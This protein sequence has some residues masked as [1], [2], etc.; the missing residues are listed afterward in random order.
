MDTHLAHI[1]GFIV[2]SIVRVPRRISRAG[3]EAIIGVLRVHGVTLLKLR[4]GILGQD[5]G[6]RSP[7][8]L[9]KGGDRS[10]DVRDASCLEFA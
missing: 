8:L 4:V 2:R 1:V 3:R 10:G 7:Y 9:Q 6:D 5:L